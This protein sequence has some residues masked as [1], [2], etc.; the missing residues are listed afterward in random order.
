MLKSKYDFLVTH[1][2]INIIL[3]IENANKIFGGG[4]LKNIN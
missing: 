1:Q 2:E 3:Q 4:I